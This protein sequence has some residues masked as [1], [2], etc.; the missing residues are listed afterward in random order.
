MQQIVLC[1]DQPVYRDYL[2]DVLHEISL[3]EEIAARPTI[4]YS[5]SCTTEVADWIE[6]EHHGLHPVPVAADAPLVF[7]LDIHLP[8]G[9]DAGLVL[10]E[11]VRDRFPQAYIVFVTEQLNSVFRAFRAQPFDFLPKPVTSERLAATLSSISHHHAQRN[12][13]P[14]PAPADRPRPSLS[15][16]APAVPPPPSSSSSRSRRRLPIPVDAAFPDPSRERWQAGGPDDILQIR[17]AGLIYR[18]RRDAIRY[19]ER[20]DDRTFVHEDGRTVSCGA[21]IEQLEKELWTPDGVFVRCHRR[22]LVNL[23][24]ISE[25]DAERR[26]LQLTSGQRFEIGRR[27]LAPLQARIRK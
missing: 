1:E 2:V 21:S 24:Y 17:S 25:I 18:V 4:L 8:E 19:I 5:G 26:S 12:G 14:L 16:P 3:R 10:A 15:D 13:L 23:R 20:T 9:S 6:A 11:T 27:Y 22:T 7:L